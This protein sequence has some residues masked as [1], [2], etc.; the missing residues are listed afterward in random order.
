MAQNFKNYNEEI[1]RWLAKQINNGKEIPESKTIMKHHYY[2]PTEN[3]IALGTFAEPVG[4]EVPIFS[5]TGKNIYI[6]KI[7]EDNWQVNLGG[8]KGN[9]CIV[10]HG[11]GQKIDGIKNIRLEKKHLIL[12][13][14]QRNV[15]I[16]ISSQ[17]HIE[18]AEKTVR[19]FKD[20]YEFL[21]I[22]KNMIQGTITKEL[23]PCYEYSQNTIKK[24]KK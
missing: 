9:V 19:S 12:E 17:H 13:L 21:T 5:E 18:L 20:G 1:H 3:S 11:W 4:T 2:M 23:V 14:E 7:G 10:P 24:E 16:E 22:G 6:F 15:P 8:N